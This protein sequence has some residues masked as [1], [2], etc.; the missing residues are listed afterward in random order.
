MARY[1]RAWRIDDLDLRSGFGDVLLPLLVA[2]MSFLAALALAGAFGCADLAQ[3]WQG[4]TLGLLT[5]QVPDGAAPAAGGSR[6]AAVLGALQ[7]DAAVSAVHRFSDAEVN[8]LLAPWLGG[9][10]T[11][12]A[13]PLPAVIGARWAGGD[14][15]GLAAA[16]GKLAPG[17][18]V[19][20]GAGWASRITALTTSLQAC[21]AAVLL[22]VTGV[23]CAIVAVATRAGLVQRR[24]TIEIIHSLGAFDGDIAERFAARATWRTAVGALFGAL[25]A[26]PVLIWLSTLAAPFGGDDAAPGLAPPMVAMVPILPLSAAALGWV[27]AQIT[28]RRWLRRLV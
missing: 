16:L 17:T 27:T 25:V 8:A 19:E 6:V 1:Q 21:A 10:A 23:A 20:T 2:A 28:V 4:D 24:E 13:L 15:A 3:H 22:I 14:I 9:T 7:G 12:L 5:V 26:L 11:A 18:L